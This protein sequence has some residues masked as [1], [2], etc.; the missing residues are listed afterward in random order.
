M[1]VNFKHHSL[2][3]YNHIYVSVHVYICLR[4]FG[5]SYQPTY[6]PT[7]L[8]SYLHTYPKHYHCLFC[9]PINCIWYFLPL[10]ASHPYLPDTDSDSRLVLF[11][12]WSCLDPWYVVSRHT[13]TRYSWWNHQTVPLT[14]PFLPLRSTLLQYSCNCI[15]SLPS[16]LF[17]EPFLPSSLPRG[18]YT[19]LFVYPAQPR[20][21]LITQQWLLVI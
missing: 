15:H 21:P 6:L 12:G 5:S 16:L 14:V 2:D 4:A 8:P 11:S 1:Q 18:P 9:Y 3:T 17:L 7:H 19:C 20:H 10:F 13:T